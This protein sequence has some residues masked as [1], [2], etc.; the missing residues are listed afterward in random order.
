MILVFFAHVFGLLHLFLIYVKKI[1]S[2]KKKKE[3]ERYLPLTAALK[4]VT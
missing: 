1:K 3:E 2:I 4:L